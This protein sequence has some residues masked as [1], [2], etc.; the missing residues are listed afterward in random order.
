MPMQMQDGQYQGN[1]AEV[2]ML[3]SIGSKWRDLSDDMGQTKR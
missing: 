2:M 1:N 3:R